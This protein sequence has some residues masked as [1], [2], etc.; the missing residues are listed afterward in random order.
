MATNETT[1][2]QKRIERKKRQVQ[3]IEEKGQRRS[4]S[5]QRKDNNQTT[6]RDTHQK[7]AKTTKG[8]RRTW[9]TT[10]KTNRRTKTNGER[11]RGWIQEGSMQIHRDEATIVKIPRRNREDKLRKD[12]TR[13]P[14]PRQR[15]ET[16]RKRWNTRS[17][18]YQDSKNTRTI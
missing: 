11:V 10:T 14:I 8:N 2:W 4:K 9:K 15:L 7:T 16:T 12:T 5:R 13:W 17:M 18:P 1:G 6:R 3:R